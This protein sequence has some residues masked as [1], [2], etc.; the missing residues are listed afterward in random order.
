MPP[1][2]WIDEFRLLDDYRLSHCCFNDDIQVRWSLHPA[3]EYNVYCS[4]PYLNAK[5]KGVQC[6]IIPTCTVMNYHGSRC[7]DRRFLSLRLLID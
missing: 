4:R 5:L 3:I 6:M 1:L 7:A 2:A